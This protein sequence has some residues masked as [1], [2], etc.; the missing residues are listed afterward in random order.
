MSE[1]FSHGP[2]SA[3]TLVTGASG[4]VGSALVERLARDGAS[5]RAAARRRQDADTHSAGPIDHVVVPDLSATTDWSAALDGIDVV[6]HCAARAHMLRDDAADPL[7]SFR[8]VNVDGTARLARAAAAAG[9]RRFVFVSSIGVNGSQTFGRPF[10]AEDLPAPQTPYAR[11]KLE[12][13]QVL[14]AIASET[15][16]AVT[17]VRPPLVYG[18]HAPGNF[19]TL[20][21]AVRRGLPLPLASVRNRRSFIGR[22]NLVDLLA[23]CSSHPLAAGLTLLASDGEDL[24]TPELVRR[25]ARA[26][27][28]P[29]RLLP[30]PP[31]WLLHAARIAGRPALGQQL[32]GSLQIDSSL[33][34][35]RLGWSPP[36]SVDEELGE[37]ARAGSAGANR[38][39]ASTA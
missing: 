36:S 27:R 14:S 31:S 4:F 18:P 17:V 25:I 32:C 30:V 37:M 9:V 28:V 1:A 20:V 19:S 11:S 34:N 12:A 29:P 15:G 8:A 16:M 2:G 38:P 24:S 13:E 3:R 10:T 21:R 35:Q 39:A 7:A 26:L 23:R 6:V 5:V 33:A 22:S